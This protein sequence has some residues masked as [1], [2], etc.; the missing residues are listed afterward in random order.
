M[1]KS[2]IVKEVYRSILNDID[3]KVIAK[4]NIFSLSGSTLIH[5]VINH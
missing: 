2:E 4:E 3:N 5:I 1:N